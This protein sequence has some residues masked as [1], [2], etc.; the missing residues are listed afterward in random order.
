MADARGTTRDRAARAPRRPTAATPSS[1][2]PARSSPSAAS[3][4]AYEE[5]RDDDAGDGDATTDRERRLPPLRGGRRARRCSGSTPDGHATQPPARYTEAIAGQGARGAR[6]RPSVDVRLDHRHDP[7]PRLRRGSAAA[8]WC[9]RSLAFAVVDAAREALRRAGRLRLHR[10]D[11]GRPRRRSPTAQAQRVDMA[12]PVLLRRGGPARGTGRRA[13]PGGDGPG[14][15]RWSATSARSTPARSTRSRSATAIVLRVGRYGPYVEREHRHRTGRRA[16]RAPVP[17][18]LAPDEL[19]VEK[20]E[21]LLVAP[22]AATA[23]SASTRAPA[24]RSSRRPAASG[25]TC[26][27]VLPD[28]APEERQAAHRVAVQDDEPRH[29]HPRRGAAAALAAARWSASTRPTA[30]RSP[31]RTAATART[32][33]RAPTPARSRPRSSSSRSRSTRRWR[34]SPSPSRAARPGRRA[35]AAR[36]GRRPGQRQADRGQGGPLRRRTSPTARPTR[37][38]ARATPSRRSTVERAAE[39]LAEKRAKGPAPKKRAPPRARPR[40]ARP[41]PGADGARR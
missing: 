20:A 28:D 22:V 15:T 4:R 30:R 19:T 31:R 32:S 14:C 41:R 33:R 38:C 7:G 29:G 21:E 5:G 16:D 2:R 24:G 34:S 13:G 17:E 35:A 1:R 26:T 8:R 11:G 40:L 27:E 36:A 6:H 9:R 39:L 18:D 37:P 23:S 3:S 25:R 10:A 12:A